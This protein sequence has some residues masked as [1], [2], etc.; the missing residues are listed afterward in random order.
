M[1]TR[2][3]QSPPHFLPLKRFSLS[4]VWSFYLHQPS[5]NRHQPIGLTW[6]PSESATNSA[7]TTLS[8]NP[9]STFQL[10][11]T[12]EVIRAI[13]VLEEPSTSSIQTRYPSTMI[14]TTAW[15]RNPGWDMRMSSPLFPFWN[16][17]TKLK[18][19]FH[20]PTLWKDPGRVGSLAQT[21]WWAPKQSK[22]RK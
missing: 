14:Q 13:L 12:F 3:H 15:F 2:V 18:W 11:C 6:T 4:L 17:T 22:L 1:R 7:P 5:P 10:S 9:T 16:R 19:K 8:C 21:L 20:D